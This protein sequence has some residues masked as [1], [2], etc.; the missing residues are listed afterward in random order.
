[1]SNHPN[2]RHSADSN[3]APDAIKAARAAAGLTQTDAA[4]LIH[5]TL[6]TWQQWEAGDRRMH[7]G[8][9]ELWQMKT[10]PP[11]AWYDPTTRQASADKESLP[12]G[13]QIWPLFP[14]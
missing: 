3:P 14:H 7:P 13:A 6:R 8:L 2:R 12:R 11:L 1:M 4:R 9:W 10:Q 5:S